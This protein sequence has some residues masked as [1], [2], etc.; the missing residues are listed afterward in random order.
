M[1]KNI[2]DTAI[3]MATQGWSLGFIP[4]RRQV[5]KD[6]GYVHNWSTKEFVTYVRDR[7]DKIP[8]QRDHAGPGQ[9]KDKDNGLNS[10]K[11]DGL[12]N[13]D[14]IHIDPW[15]VYPKIEDA[16]INTNIMIEVGG[17]LIFIK[18]HAKQFSFDR[19][20]STMHSNPI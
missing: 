3:E 5:D 20:V 17:L 11:E 18:I 12:N 1:S 14:L 6:R 10:L 8:I 16:V 15:K 7:T 13:L 9:G 19:V 2:V 4:S